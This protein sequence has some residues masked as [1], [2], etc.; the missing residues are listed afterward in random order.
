MRPTISGPNITRV[1]ILSAILT[2]IISELREHEKLRGDST[3][4]LSSKA[5]LPSFLV[6]RHQ[7]PSRGRPAY[8][9]Q[10]WTKPAAAAFGRRLLAATVSQNSSGGLLAAGSRQ[11]MAAPVLLLLIFSIGQSQ[12]L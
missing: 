2:A 7:Y 4:S 10:A 8:A 5:S 11:P 6:V 1:A 12:K 9:Q 3:P